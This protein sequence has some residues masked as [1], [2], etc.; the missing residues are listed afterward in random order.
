[1]YRFDVCPEVEELI[2]E[3]FNSKF[4][5]GLTDYPDKI[6][7]K[8][9]VP[10]RALKENERYMRTDWSMQDNCFTFTFQQVGQGSMDAWQSIAMTKDESQKMLEVFKISVQ[11]LQSIGPLEIQR[12]LS[13]AAKRFSW[14]SEFYS[15]PTKHEP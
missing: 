4:S 2:L 13:A 9:D 3:R 12:I 11:C 14:I 6:K 10:P 5:N 8:F 1:M 7:E 15:P